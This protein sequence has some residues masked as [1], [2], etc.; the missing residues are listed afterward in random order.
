MHAAYR[1][2]HPSIFATRSFSLSR[3]PSPKSGHSALSMSCTT[4]NCAL[5]NGWIASRRRGPTIANLR[6][7]GDTGWSA[8]CGVRR[9]TLR[10]VRRMPCACLSIGTIRD[11]RRFHRR[12]LP[13]SARVHLIPSAWLIEWKMVR[14]TSSP[15]TRRVHWG[16]GV[17]PRRKTCRHNNTWRHDDSAATTTRAPWRRG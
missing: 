9:D 11:G 3:T 6:R 16:S 12:P 1:F 5:K 8:R 13:G 2:N 10:E 7:A 17:V 15:P 4:P 14:S